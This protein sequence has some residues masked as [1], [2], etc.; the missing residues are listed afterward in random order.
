MHLIAVS[1]YGRDED[2]ARARQAGFD[3]HFTKPVDPG[4]LMSALNRD[5]ENGQPTRG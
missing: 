3:L 5:R 2:R 1:G 4:E